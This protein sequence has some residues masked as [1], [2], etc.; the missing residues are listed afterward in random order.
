MAGMIRSFFIRL[1]TADPKMNSSEITQLF[2]PKII[3]EDNTTLCKEFSVEEISDA[4][5]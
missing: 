3:E 2:E 4:M 1:Y 5:F